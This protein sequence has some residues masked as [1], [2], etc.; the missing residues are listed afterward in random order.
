MLEKAA[1][2]IASRS[3]S[4]GGMDPAAALD[5]IYVICCFSEDQQEQ[6]FEELLKLLES[7]PEIN[8]VLVHNIA[9][10]FMQDGETKKIFLHFRE[11]LLEYPDKK[12]K[13]FPHGEF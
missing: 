8:L 7:D 1:P 10:L 11:A 12:A 3:L 9:T 13:T 4:P 6:A 5:N 2:A